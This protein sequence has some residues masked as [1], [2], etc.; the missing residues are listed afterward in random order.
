M[1]GKQP[2]FKDYYEIKLQKKREEAEK[3][4]ALKLKELQEYEKIKLVKEQEALEKQAQKEK[5]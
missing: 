2:L 3:E 1:E 5:Q 4:K